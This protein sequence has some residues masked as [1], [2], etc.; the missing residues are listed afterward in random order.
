[1]SFIKSLVNVSL[2]V[3]VMALVPTSYALVDIDSINIANSPGETLVAPSSVVVVDPFI[4]LDNDGNIDGVI[5][6]LNQFADNKLILDTVKADALGFDVQNLESKGL[7]I[8]IAQASNGADPRKVQQVLRLVEIEVG[9]DEPDTP[10]EVTFSVGKD[11]LFNSENSHFY[12]YIVADKIDWF[13]AYREAEG[14]EIYGF[15][16][17]LV[18]ITSESEQ[19]FVKVKVSGE[20][21]M[22]ASDANPAKLFDELGLVIDT[23]AD[24]VSIGEDEWFWVSG[25][26][27]GQRFWHGLGR[28]SIA[29]EHVPATAFPIEGVDGEDMYHNWRYHVEPNN[30]NDE[31]FLHMWGDGIWNDFKRNSGHINGY[32][33][34]YGD[35]N[36]ILQNLFTTKTIAYGENSDVKFTSELNVSIA[37]TKTLVMT[38]KAENL[39][40]VDGDSFSFELTGVG[41][42]L[43][44]LDADDKLLF[45][46]APKDESGVAATDYPVEITVTNQFDK[47]NTQIFII[48]ALLD[49]DN[50]GLENYLADSD[51]DNDGIKDIFEDFH[52]D[53]IKNDFDGDGIINSLDDD[54]DGDGIL[55]KDET[56]ADID[57]DGY[58]NF[59]DIDSDGDLIS[60][61]YETDSDFDD[62]GIPNAYDVDSDDDLVPDV[63]EAQFSMLDADGNGIIDILDMNTIVVIDLNNDGEVDNKDTLIL[64]AN[65]DGILDALIMYV[66]NE[67]ISDTLIIYVNNEGVVALL[68]T[69]ADTFTDP[70]VHTDTD[71]KADI[72]DFDND[73]DGIKDIYENV[74][75]PDGT[76]PADSDSDGIID[77]FDV[78]VTLGIDLN[79]D[80][81]DDAVKM[82]DTDGDGVA[83]SLDLDSDNDGILDIVEYEQVDDNNNRA[84]SAIDFNDDGINDNNVDFVFA[85]PADTDADGIPD[86][87]DSDSDGDGVNDIEATVFRNFDLDDDGKIDLILFDGVVTSV[88]DD[89]DGI[90]GFADDEPYQRGSSDDTDGDGI[91]N[92]I[93]LDDDNDGI[94]DIMERVNGVDGDADNDGIIDRLDPDSDNDGISDR[95]EAGLP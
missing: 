5:V 79:Q 25:P 14:R 53:P 16:G 6:S 84:P 67:G 71:G 9:A 39:T 29:T 41:A 86:F 69:Q 17:Y 68:D 13:D 54:S 34:E 8:V 63:L 24:G 7:L 33:V 75:A 62:D 20:A 42:N 36:N 48:T 1:M 76:E 26:E 55:D 3:G 85:A 23:P 93:D 40:E 92:R 60:D 47:T 52:D 11:A 12:E 72:Y 80:G 64:D 43:F 2:F 44:S 95:I 81:I 31:D 59:I 21:W 65:S 77:Y 22:G 45:N 61:K 87:K 28:D 10:I 89:K 15:P 58:G 46:M 70:L 94:S 18:T 56:A 66:N 27:T 74:T 82:L 35:S 38:I 51:D 32:I 90:V 57:N 37:E 19:D 88:D 49:S 78:D 50:D 73:N 30:S 4:T 91:P 83:D